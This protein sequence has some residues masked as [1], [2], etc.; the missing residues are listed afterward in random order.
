MYMSFYLPSYRIYI[1]TIVFTSLE[2]FSV[3]EGYDLHQSTICKASKYKKV[4]ASIYLW[5]KNK[6][7]KPFMR[8]EQSNN[9]RFL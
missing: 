4:D 8:R 5:R 2:S 6:S 9:K 1:V 7:L 3:L